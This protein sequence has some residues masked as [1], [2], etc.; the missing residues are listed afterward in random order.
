MMKKYCLLLLVSSTFHPARAQCQENKAFALLDNISHHNF[1]AAFVYSSQSSQGKPGETLEGNIAVQGH[2]YR[3]SMD[4][5]EIVN[6]G[7][8]IWTYLTYANEVQITNHHP[9]QAAATPWAIL[10]NYRQDYTVLD[11]CTQE[12][13]QH[14]YD[15]INLQAKDKEH[16]LPHIT[17]TIER[18]TKH[19]KRL[20]TLD[21]DQTLHI[22]SITDF[23]YDLKFDKAFFNFNTKEYVA[24]EIIDMR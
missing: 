14:V 19:I 11:L 12:I 17:L 24:I 9:E 10:N 21:S 3:L 2:Q 18:T 5:Q 1:Q 16:S 7:T 23:A 6:D 13:D 22:F 20:A 8:T 4:G 15:V